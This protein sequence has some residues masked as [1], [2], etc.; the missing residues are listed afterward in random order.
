M[1]ANNQAGEAKQGATFPLDGQIASVN[2]QWIYLS[3]PKA[4]LKNASLKIDIAGVYQGTISVQQ[5]LDKTLYGIP[6]PNSFNMVIS[7]YLRQDHME[8]LTNTQKVKFSVPVLP[9]LPNSVLHLQAVGVSGHLYRSKPVVLGTSS[10]AMKNTT[11]FSAT[12]DAPVSVPVQ[13]QRVPDIKYQ[14][15][16]DHGSVL[17]ADAGRPFWAILGGYFALATGRG[18][19][20][21]Q[22]AT[23]FVKYESD[24]PKDAT[25]SAPMWV[26]LDDGN[27]ALQFDGKG[28]YISLPQGVIPRRAAFTISM[29][30]KPDSVTGKQMIIANQNYYPGS[31]AVYTE[32][33]VLKADYKG[34]P[35]TDESGLDSGLKLPID[36]WSHLV[37][38]YDQAGITFE[39]D[40]KASKKFAAKGPG[41][42]DTA[43]V[44]GGFGADWFKGQIKSLE[45]EQ[46][47][48]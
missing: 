39:V 31:I 37:I 33:G 1:I 35:D 3:I 5:I 17:I 21:R 44:V 16:P 4:Q 36:K 14:F 32:D 43:S 24:Y 42:Y 9:D 27:Y 18:G 20:A 48:G 40:G 15:N 23:S 45:I 28:T 29:D 47:V 22:D 19:G 10:S 38:R 7:R 12:K 30:I 11:V 46:G 25:Q 6:G 34:R 41:L 8:T 26:H 2:P 13:S